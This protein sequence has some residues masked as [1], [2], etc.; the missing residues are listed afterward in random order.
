MEDV[1]EA[2]K[3]ELKNKKHLYHLTLNLKQ[4]GMKE[5]AEALLIR[6]QLGIVIKNIYKSYDL[7][8]A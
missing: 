6:A 2:G 1:E 4:V 8:L 5:V 3:A 7:I